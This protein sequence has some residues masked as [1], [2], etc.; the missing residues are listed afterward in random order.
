MKVFLEQIEGDWLDD[1]VF[2]TKDVFLNSGD[3]VVPF[4]GL[5]LPNSILKH[6][7]DPTADICIGS[8][9]ATEVFFKICG[10]DTPKAI[11]Y[12][13]KLRDFLGRIIK[14]TTFDELGIDYPYF[15]KPSEEIKLFTGD[16]VESDKDKATLIKYG[17]CKATTKVYRSELVNFVSEYRV[18]VSLGEVKGIRHYRGNPLILFD[19]ILIPLMVEA[20]TDCPLAYTLD[21]GVTSDGRTL[22]VEVNDMWAIASYGLNPRDYT[23]LCVRRL[24]QILKQIK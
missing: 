11:S 20:Y 16:S 24:K 18:F 14:E 7:V 19:P 2:I 6:G 4:D 9:E 8:V 15:V 13:K 17:N 12:P 1:F 3:I 21:I 23:L 10:V 5:D 22:L